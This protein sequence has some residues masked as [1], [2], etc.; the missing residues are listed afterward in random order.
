MIKLNTKIGKH[1]LQMEFG[2]MKD[3]HK[4]GSIYGNLPQKCTN[5]QSDNIY[6]SYKNPKG[7]DYYTLAC[8]DCTADAN[9][10]IK[11]EDGGL[12]WKAEKMSIYVASDSQNQ[13]NV[14]NAQKEFGGTIAPGDDVAF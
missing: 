5:C 10:G 12:F 6:L 11:K 13:E 7:N 4:F 3:L 9:F 14:D 8:G 2:K 1:T